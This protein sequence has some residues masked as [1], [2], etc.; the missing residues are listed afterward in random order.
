MVAIMVVGARPGLAASPAATGPS[1]RVVVVPG[2]LGGDALYR[3]MRRGLAQRGF[4]ARASGI[5][6]NAG[7]LRPKIDRVKAAVIAEHEASGGPVQL[8][9][10]SLG[11]SIAAIAAHELLRERPEVFEGLG[12][13]PVVA[14]LAAPLDMAHRRD[15]ASRILN[16]LAPKLIPDF[17]SVGERGLLALDRDRTVPIAAGYGLHDRLVFRRG[18]TL[19]WAGS[20]V[21]QRGGHLRMLF[22]ADALAAALAAPVSRQP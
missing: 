19:P 4:T 17:G 18:A 13:R 2:F 1:P 10:H 3:V 9:G 22:R 6:F 5:R 7:R 16:W 14:T 20:F 21:I 15:G 11:G 8:A 12:A